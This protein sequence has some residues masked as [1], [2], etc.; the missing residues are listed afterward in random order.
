MAAARDRH[1]R[2]DVGQSPSGSGEMVDRLGGLRSST[3]HTAARVGAK[4][5]ASLVVHSITT[6][7]ANMR[8][9][10]H[11][12]AHDDVLTPPCNCMRRPVT[13]GNSQ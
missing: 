4:R 13:I 5:K 6:D 9:I 2:Y 7:F 12:I 1:A 8:D 3:R 10:A 11:D